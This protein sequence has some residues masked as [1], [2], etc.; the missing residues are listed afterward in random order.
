VRNAL[1]ILAL[2]ASL[3]R[4]AKA[5]EIGGGLGFPLPTAEV[6]D[7]ELGLHGGLTFTLFPPAQIGFGMDAVY[8]HWPV[9]PEFKT[10]VDRQLLGLL[11]ID[12]PTW[13]ISAIQTTAHFKLIAPLRAAFR[14]WLQC[15]AGIYLVNPRLEFMGD[16]L[17]SKFERGAY[18]SIGFDYAANPRLRIGLDASYHYVWMKDDMG[19]DFDAWEMGTHLLFGRGWP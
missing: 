8:H 10:S 9:S 13:N 5:D 2:A 17:D 6:G 4:P 16:N 11:K 7:H 18:G 3:S 19:S 1:L 15:G 14:P 12:A